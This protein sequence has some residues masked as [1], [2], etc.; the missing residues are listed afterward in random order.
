MLK[1]L[2]L[3]VA[4][5]I[6]A[7]RLRAVDASNPQDKHPSRDSELA[8]TYVP[9]DSWVYSAFERLAAEGYIQTAFLSLRPWTRLD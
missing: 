2:V 6:I 9:L 3:L 4:C 7:P 8:S 1:S 5:V